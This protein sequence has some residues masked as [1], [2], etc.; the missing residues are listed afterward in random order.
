M[1]RKMAVPNLADLRNIYSYREV[2]RV[3]STEYVSIGRPS[4]GSD[5]C[6]NI[7]LEQGASEQILDGKCEQ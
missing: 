1:A 3:G 5:D 4:A 7:M 6:S 2:V